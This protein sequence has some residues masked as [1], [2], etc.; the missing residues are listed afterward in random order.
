MLIQ[1]DVIIL[2]VKPSKKRTIFMNVLSRCHGS[3]KV[4]FFR[5][6]KDYR[7]PQPGDIVAA[8]WDENGVYSVPKINIKSHHFTMFGSWG[9]VIESILK[10]TRDQTEAKESYGQYLSLYE[11]QKALH[12]ATSSALSIL[13]AI[14]PENATET[15]IWLE[16]QRFI[17]SASRATNLAQLCKLYLDWEIFIL[18]LSGLI[19]D[20]WFTKET[21]EVPEKMIPRFAFKVQNLLYNERYYDHTKSYPTYNSKPIWENKILVL[22]FALYESAVILKHHCFDNGPIPPARKLLAQ[23]IRP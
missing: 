17:K 19:T 14:M 5:S 7:S 11:A 6:K 1:D 9:P 3:Q 23:I 10:A 8:E 13:D 15:G 4:L 21:L 20:Q 12:T 16:T 2:S 22:R 18:S